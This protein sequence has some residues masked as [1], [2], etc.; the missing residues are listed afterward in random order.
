MIARM[1]LTAALAKAAKAVMVYDLI[2][3]GTDSHDQESSFGLFD[4]NFQPKEAAG[5]FRTIADLMASCDT[6]EFNADARRGVIFA[7]F[8]AGAS[9]SY[10]IWTYKPGP[11]RNICF[12]AGAWA[13]PAVLRDLSGTGLS[14]QTC[15]G[16]TR[17]KLSLSDSSG[18]VILQ[19][20]SNSSK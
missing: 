14:L 4:Y 10:L 20:D 2:D 7:T 19:P 6:Y 12:D 11:P 8:H 1:M 16:T 18:P 3:D 17:V 5:V 15:G 9:A 13:H